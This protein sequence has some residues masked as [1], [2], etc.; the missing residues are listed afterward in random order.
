MLKYE[1]ENTSV[2]YHKELDGGGTTF[3]V[4]ALRGEEVQKRIVRGNI[5]E[6]CSGPGFMG[7]YLNDIGLADTLHLSD[8]N[9]ENE[10]CIDRTIKQNGL[11]NVKFIQ[12]S[13]FERI[14]TDLKFDTI[15][16][17]PP[18]FATNRENG[19]RSN[20][21]RLISLDEDMKIHKSIFEDADKYLNPNGRLILVENAT[22]IS[23]ED[24]KK[25]I[26]NKWG[27]EYVEYSDYNWKGKST[28]YTI[29]LYLL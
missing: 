18:H 8:I 29:I 12:S 5:L 14:P 6:L 20:H 10:E 9:I 27:I 13:V 21:E 15:I 23:E 19:Y 26:G 28:F 22:G 11:T 17:N 7:A 4:E 16:S 2:Y 24:I 25:L 3:G 1:L